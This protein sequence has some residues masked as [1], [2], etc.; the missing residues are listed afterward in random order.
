MKINRSFLDGYTSALGHI[1]NLYL[2]NYTAE[3][4]DVPA[5]TQSIHKS[6][7]RVGHYLSSSFTQFD[8]TPKE[9]RIYVQKKNPPRKKRA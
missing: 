5:G 7:M 8:V 3:P 6:W 9:K 2:G 4:I 1:S